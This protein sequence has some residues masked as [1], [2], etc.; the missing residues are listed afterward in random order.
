MS[1][2]NADQAEFWR[3]GDGDTW[4]ARQA[5]LDGLMQP[6]LDG[7]LAR[8]NLMNDQVV[9]DIGCGTG[10]STLQAA[11]GVGAAG[12]VHGLDISPT[13]LARAR[14]RAQ[15]LDNVKFIEAD[16]ADFNFEPA[17]F[18]QMISRFGTMFFADAVGA[19]SNMR[20]AMR[21]G[22]GMSCA[23][24]GAIANNPW[25]TY[26]A[27][28]AKAVLGAPPAVDPD[29]PGPFSMRDP[30]RVRDVL[31]QAGYEDIRVAV[32]ALDLTPQGTRRDVAELAVNV[33]PAGRTILHFNGTDADQDAISARIFDSYAPFETPDGL[34][35]PAEIVF[36]Q[37]KAPHT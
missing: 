15:D 34:R 10:A 9:L 24:W 26:S 23:S 36:F 3:S 20:K 32:S 12:Q 18:D 19:F 27:A 2:S 28:A 11:E 21:P 5:A 29:A 16:A 14:D 33:G 8:A 7:V 31:E 13:M 6:V 4:V 35:I 25:F 22:A 17:L 37:A 1:G 30:E